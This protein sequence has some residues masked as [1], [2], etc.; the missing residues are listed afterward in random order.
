MELQDII[1][2]PRVNIDIKRSEHKPISVSFG[3]TKSSN[4]HTLKILFG[5]ECNFS[6]RYCY[7][8]HKKDGIPSIP[9]ADVRELPDSL[10][11]GRVEFW[12]GETLLYQEL[13]IEAVKQLRTR[14][15]QLYYYIATNGSLLTEEFVDFAAENNIGIGISHD[16]PGQHNRS[17]DPFK[18]NRMAMIYAHKRL[19]SI[20]RMSFNPILTTESYTKSNIERY[21]EE[22]LGTKDFMLGEGGWINVAHDNAMK[23]AVTTEELSSQIAWET[24]VD[25]FV[26]EPR[27]FNRYYETMDRI[28]GFL[29][30]RI[31]ISY[32]PAGCDIN[33]PGTISVDSNRNILLCHSFPADYVL[34]SG[35]TNAI[36]DFSNPDLAEIKGFNTWHYKE[37]RDCPFI[38]ACKKTCHLAGDRFWDVNC[39]TRRTEA[40]PYF[41]YAIY[42][43]TGAITYAIESYNNTW[44]LLNDVGGLLDA[45]ESQYNHSNQQP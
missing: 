6:C 33:C 9:W 30:D 7:Q 28:Y 15:K 45:I 35:Q 39:R 41:V 38:L 42:T 4:F 21:F 1:T 26:H 44:V 18:I 37:C 11:G 12:G 10:E 17:L 29:Q 34:D 22:Q 31:P 24:T 27:H 25:I 5:T 23:L 14:Y 40:I 36:G 32:L 43:A 2:P 19:A 16:G 3:V 8:S 20:G 13:I